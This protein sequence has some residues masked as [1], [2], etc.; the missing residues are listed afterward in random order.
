[1]QNGTAR[2]LA[3]FLGSFSLLNVAG[4][5]LDPH[6]DASIWWIDFRP[7]PP[8]VG[9]LVL[10]VCSLLILGWALRTRMSR[11]RFL[12]TRAAVL[13][14]I[15]VVIA[16]CA[17]YYVLLFR[18]EIRTDFPFP[19]SA[20]ILILLIGIFP[21]PEPRELRSRRERQAALLSLAFCVL[22]FP[23]SQILS[24]GRTDYRR[25]AQAIVV[26]GARTYSDG[27][28]S[29]ALFDRT[30]TAIDLYQKGFAP[31]MI[32]SGGP[33]DGEIHETEAMRRFAVES[34][35]PARHIR[36]DLKGLNTRRTVA[37][38]VAYFQRRKVR[39][40]LA[41]SHYFHLPRIKMAY[42][43]AGFDVLTVPA[44]ESYVLYQ[45]PYLLV[46]ETAA[47]WYYYLHPLFGPATPPRPLLGPET[48]SGK[49]PG[50]PASGAAAVR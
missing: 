15:G 20:L 41:V 6:F 25:P 21:G 43:R 10:A 5:F 37:N 22:V 28:M 47:L 46:R 17:V 31:Q 34:G 24:F 42:Q 48:A 44:E 27:S 9:R 26:F 29:Q 30:R 18:G 1:M 40:V 35:V 2:G 16:N 7:L 49:A 3:I 23:I 12:L 45:T 33:G 11:P 4:G 32:F 19:F 39:R 8:V 38:T 50:T 13:V 14:L 36:K